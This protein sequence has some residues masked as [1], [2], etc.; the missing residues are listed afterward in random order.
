MFLKKIPDIQVLQLGFK[1][2][3][4]SQKRPS[5]LVRFGKTMRGQSIV[6]DFKN[7]EETFYHNLDLLSKAAVSKSWQEDL[8]KS[9][10]Y[11]LLKRS[12]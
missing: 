3:F 11:F 8:F 2:Q 7:Y 12:K 4:Y 9:Q 5:V 6:S 1:I 10:S